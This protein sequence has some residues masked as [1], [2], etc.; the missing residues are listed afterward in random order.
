MEPEYYNFTGR[1]GEVVPDHVTHVLIDKALKF[2]RGRAFYEHPNIEE[3]ICHDG[4]E[5]IEQY[6]FYICPSLRRVIMSGVKEVQKWA[7]YGCTSLAYLEC[8]KLEIIGEWAFGFCESLSSIDLLSIKIVEQYVFTGCTNLTNAKFGKDLESIGEETFRGCPSLESIT[9]PLKDGMISHDDTFLE[10]KK[11]ESVDLVEGAVMDESIAALL[12]EQWKNDMN[13][14]IDAINQIL[15]NTPA[16]NSNMNEAGGKAREIRTWISSVLRKYTHYKSE[17]RR[18]LNEAAAILQT[19][20]P[21]DIVI[22]NV[23]LFVEL[24]SDT[25]EGED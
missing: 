9:L 3:V 15:S 25:F 19:A 8:G 22:K 7:F 11:L 13:E 18:Y 16:G 24:P 12:M 4:V 23:L 2:V 1:A 17:H 6:A 14:E 20:T 5:M 10:C 21:Y